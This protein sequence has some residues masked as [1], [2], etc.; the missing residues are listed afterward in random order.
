MVETD[1]CKRRSHLAGGVPGEVK[2]AAC[3]KGEHHEW[4]HL[5]DEHSANLDGHGKCY[6]TPVGED[7]RERKEKKRRRPRHQQHA[8][9][10]LPCHE[11]DVAKRPCN[12]EV[13]ID[14]H[15]AEIGV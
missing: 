2:K 1:L 9:D 6:V 7:G 11:G 13:A 3:H 8:A 4:K 5:E 14:R 12:G 10:G 15:G